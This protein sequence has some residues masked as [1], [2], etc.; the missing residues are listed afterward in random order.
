MLDL[1]WI[2]GLTPS[3]KWA[4]WS[5]H[6]LEVSQSYLRVS[7]RKVIVAATHREVPTS[8]SYMNPLRGCWCGR[9]GKSESANSLLTFKSTK[10]EDF[11]KKCVRWLSP[12][13]TL[14]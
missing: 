5:C 8:K 9:G 4:L 2:L 1:G 10:S 13:K 11:F 7:D 14:R 6:T 3:V 12:V